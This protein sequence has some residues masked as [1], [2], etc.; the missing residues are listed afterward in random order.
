MS[1]NLIEKL[2]KVNEEYIKK[3]DIGFYVNNTQTKFIKTK[4][5][6]VNYNWNL[7]YSEIIGIAFGNIM[8]G[9]D[10]SYFII[11]ILE[12]KKPIY[13]NMTY[14]SEEM[15]GFDKFMEKLKEKLNLEKI[16]WEQDKIV[17]AYPENLKGKELY[18]PWKSSIET[19]IHEIKRFFGLKHH[20]S[21]ILKDEYEIILKNTKTNA[22]HQI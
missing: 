2:K 3:N 17:F 15:Q 12:D 14:E 21:G 6:F 4:R 22:Q 8:R 20:A 18:K 11:F 16:F 5:H 13:F 19:F 7:K 1:E 9:D 10:D